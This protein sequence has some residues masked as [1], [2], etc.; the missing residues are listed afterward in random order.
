PQTG[1]AYVGTSAFAHKGGLHASAVARD[2]RSYEHVEPEQVGNRRQILVSDQAGK[3][4]LL[5]QLSDMGIDANPD[6]SRLGSLV[7]LVKQREFDGFAYDGALASFE[8]LAR[9]RL[10]QVPEFFELLRF[11]VTDERRYN[12]RGHL[13]A[14]SEARVKVRI[15]NEEMHT[16]AEG[17]G[18]VN[19]LD[20]ALRK[21]LEPVY[22]VLKDMRLVDYRVRILKQGDASAAMPRVQ[23]DSMN[24]DGTRWSTVGVST[25]IIEASFNALDDSFAYKLF[26]SGAAGQPTSGQPS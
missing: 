21:A 14:E 26:H 18:P 6:D 22:P 12:A 20:C 17:N 24:G 1:A 2:P 11:S 7:E 9:R 23:I 4:N 10:G 5:A 15:G 13:I 8:M 16:V 25:N 19:A 3:S